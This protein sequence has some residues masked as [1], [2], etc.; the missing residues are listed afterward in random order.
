[1]PHHDQSFASGINFIHGRFVGAALVHVDLLG[2]TT[3]LHGFFK[4][5]LDCGFVPLDCQK[6]VDRPA[7]LVYCAVEIFPGGFDQDAGF[8]RAPTP[9]HR[10]LVLEEHFLKQGQKPD[11]AA[12]D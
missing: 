2:N 9:T 11:R 7:F 1:M 3:G 4:K 8:I 5:A 10:M 6:E 12:V